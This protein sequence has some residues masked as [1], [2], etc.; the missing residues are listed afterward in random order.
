MSLADAQGLLPAA[1]FAAHQ[2]DAD[3]SALH[4]LAHLCERFSPRVGID[5]SSGL[6]CLLMDITGG[7]HLFGGDHKMA[8]QVA[9]FFSKENYFAHIAIASTIAASWAIACHGHR[10]GSQ[11]R[12]KSLPLE[13]LRLSDD[14]L[15]R[16]HEFDI[17]SVGQLLKLPRQELPSRFTASLPERLDQLFGHLHEDFV[18]VRC[19]QPIQVQWSTDDYVLNPQALRYVCADLLDE[20]LDRLQDRG[21]GIVRF[22]VQLTGASDQSVVFQ[23]GTVTPYF[24]DSTCGN[25]ARQLLE[26]LILQLNNQPVPE[27]L[28][29]V[30]MK[31]L[32][33]A[34]KEARQ[35]TLFDDDPVVTEG[36]FHRLLDRLST[37]LGP[38]AVVLSV[39]QPEPLPEDAVRY[40]PVM[41]SDASANSSLAQSAV[42]VTQAGDS[43]P[44]V[45]HFP[46]LSRPLNL[47]VPQPVSVPSV[48]A[49]N[50]PEQ[51]RWQGRSYRV[52]HCTRQERIQTGWWTSTGQT[53]RSYY[54]VQTT[55]GQ[56]FWLFCDSQQQW[57]LHGVFD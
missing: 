20:I 14:V 38:D 37:R 23:Q 36:T 52:F 1:H 30:G 51:F 24:A 42:A 15:A 10:T 2:P 53:V 21:E 56:R 40:Q 4:D 54:Q 6:T 28:H 13:A 43:T 55:T 16:L 32:Q 39:L 19:Q 7:S 46:A 49:D 35:Q 22:Q 45:Q 12:L 34:P 31:V 25:S 29:T 48:T 9:V 26:L 18:P 17:H 47:T 41:Q 44:C 8:R 11:R 5:D 27:G 50:T 33:T 57:Y 3:E